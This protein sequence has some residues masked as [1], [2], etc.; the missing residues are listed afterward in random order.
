MAF[1]WMTALKIIPSK[2][3][4]NQPASCQGSKAAFF[5]RKGGYQRIF[6]TEDSSVSGRWDDRPGQAK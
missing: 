1:G 5:R 3:C 6:G 4:P 2:S